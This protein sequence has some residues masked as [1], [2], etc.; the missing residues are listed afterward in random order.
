LRGDGQVQG[1]A[2]RRDVQVRSHH[3]L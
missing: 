1:R 2:G 3:A